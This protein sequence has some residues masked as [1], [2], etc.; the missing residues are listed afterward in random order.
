MLNGKMHTDENSDGNFIAVINSDLS[1]CIMKFS[2]I[3]YI[4][5]RNCIAGIFFQ[6]IPVVDGSD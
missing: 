4:A 6:Y 3:D 2:K 1:D 5:S